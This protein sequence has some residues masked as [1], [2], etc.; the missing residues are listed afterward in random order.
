MYVLQLYIVHQTL[1]SY[2]SISSTSHMSVNS[3]LQLINNAHCTDKNLTCD[4]SS[5]S[6]SK[7]SKPKC[8]QTKLQPVECFLLIYP[9]CCML[10]C[11]WHMMLL[12]VFYCCF[13]KFI[14]I[15][16]IWY[17]ESKMNKAKRSNQKKY[18]KKSCKTYHTLM[19]IHFKEA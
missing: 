9:Y 3:N 17:Y 15:K 16:Q 1:I 8:Y 12:N 10:M 5:K 7:N 2:Q 13:G 11:I 4:I 14:A 18:F 19:A 6:G